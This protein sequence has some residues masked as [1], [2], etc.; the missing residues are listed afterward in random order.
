ME[1]ALFPR[2]PLRPPSLVMEMT[3]FPRLPLRPPSPSRPHTLSS[4]PYLTYFPSPHALP[5][6]PR[7]TY[8]CCQ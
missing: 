6:P 1:M 4:A 5:S 3:H 8:S 2:L 7:R